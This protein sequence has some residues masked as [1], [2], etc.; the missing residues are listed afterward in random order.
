MIVSYP[1]V[2]E[3]G[4]LNGCQVCFRL[5][6]VFAIKHMDRWIRDLRNEAAERPLADRYEPV[7][8]CITVYLGHGEFN[9][10]ADYAETM[11]KMKDLNE[12]NE[13]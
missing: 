9:I 13:D 4:T 11:A 1:L 8:G 10:Q 6:T 12:W 7:P 5:G 2:N 3:D